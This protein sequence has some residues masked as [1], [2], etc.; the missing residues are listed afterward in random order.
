[1]GSASRSKE[2]TRKESKKNKDKDIRD[3]RNLEK[4]QLADA[5][6]DDSDAY[7][8]APKKRDDAGV[9]ES[10][11]SPVRPKGGRAD[12][13]REDR[14]ESGSRKEDDGGR[15]ESGSRREDDRGR[16]NDVA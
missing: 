6:S 14:R 3:R 2:A 7:V 13:R 8:I 5:A 15:R 1:M 16:H 9:R 11:T 10:S 12:D 4:V